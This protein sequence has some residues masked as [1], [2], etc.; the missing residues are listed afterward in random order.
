[1]RQRAR[2]VADT[3]C[4]VVRNINFVQKKKRRR[5]PVSPSSHP[6]T[7]AHNTNT[8]YTPTQTKQKPNKSITR[9]DM[10]E[11]KLKVVGIPSVLLVTGLVTDYIYYGI[12]SAPSED[13]A[14]TEMSGFESGVWVGCTLANVA[15]LM[16]AWVYTFDILQQEVEHLEAQEAQ[17]KGRGGAEAEHAAPVTEFDQALAAEGL[18]AYRNL[19]GANQNAAHVAGADA[20]N[21]GDVA[22]VADRLNFEVKKRLLARFS[23]GVGFYLVATVAVL[24]LPIFVNDVLQGA[25]VFL[26]FMVQLAF[27]V[28]LAVL[29]RPAPD[30]PYLMLGGD[31]D[32]AA[33]LG[34]VDLQT[35]L[36]V[37]EEEEEEEQRAAAATAAGAA[38]AAAAG[39]AAVVVRQKSGAAAAAA[40]RTTARRRRTTT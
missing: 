19:M 24:L 9:D 20:E 34:M 31:L 10:G 23:L 35:Q 13:E 7:H 11:H 26:H 16:M 27:L 17:I 29:L 6:H 37:G 12:V 30:S 38:A 3:F 25:I 8:Y 18:V 22:T 33:E 5:R 2:V 15:S 28:V 4:V 21:P 14:I 1:V 36:D 39:A 32:E 40:A